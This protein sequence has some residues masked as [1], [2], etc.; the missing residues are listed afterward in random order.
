MTGAITT[1]AQ[2]ADNPTTPNSPS[3][4]VQPAAPR[5]G[6]ISAADFSRLPQAEQDRFAILRG[7]D[8]GQEYVRRD[9]LEKAATDPAAGDPTA[10]K[11][12]GLRRS[13]LKGNF[14]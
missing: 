10:A 1:T 7:P 8:G 14:A 13:R 9:Q 2:A 12:G 5:P 11:P 4:P 3:T 6:S